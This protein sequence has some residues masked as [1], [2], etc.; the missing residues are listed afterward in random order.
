MSMGV[1]GTGRNAT[2][3]MPHLILRC[4]YGPLLVTAF[5][6]VAAGVFGLAV[7][8]FLNVVIYRVPAEL[9]VVRPRSRCP[10]CETTLAERDNIPVLS[11]LI[12]RGRCRTCQEP[13]SARYPA[14]ELLTGVLFAVMAARLGADW[15]LP[16]F[17]VWT[18]GLV[19]LS[20]IDLDTFTLPRKIIY[21]TGAMCAVLLAVAAVVDSDPRSL[22]DAVIGAAI[23]FAVLFVIHFISPKGMGFGDV[24]LAG[25]L[26]LLLGWLGLGHVG[27]GLF[28]AFLLASVVGIALIVTKRKGRKDRVPFGPFLAGG[29][30]LAVLIGEWALELYLPG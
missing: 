7:G 4:G 20:F 2:V 19:A 6:V 10:R 9:S 15:A 27:V 8:S 22:R 16:A 28:A 25:L 14:V 23:A 21:V 24:R 12:L 1:R 5:I 18:A 30:Y 29:A 3:T 11:W 17:L 26:G 13:I